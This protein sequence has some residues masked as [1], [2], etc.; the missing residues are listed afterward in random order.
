MRSHK[1]TPGPHYDS[2]ATIAASEDPYILE[3]AFTSYFLRKVSWVIGKLFL[4]VCKFFQKKLVHSMSEHFQTPVNR[5]NNLKLK[6][7]SQKASSRAAQNIL[8]GHMW[9]FM[10]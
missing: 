2:D 7:Y 9:P 8:A 10:H 5:L 4:A 6:S 3:T 1:V